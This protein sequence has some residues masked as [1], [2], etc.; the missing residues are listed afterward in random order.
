MKAREERDKLEFMIDGAESHLQGNT[1]APG[2]VPELESEPSF[3]IDYEK[4]QKTCDKQAKKLLKNAT[5]L[6]IG[7]ELTKDNSYIRY[8]IQTDVISLGGMLYQMEITKIMQQDLVEEVRLGAKHPRMYE[9]FSTLGKTISDN[10]KQLLQTVEAIKETYVTLRQNIV[11]RNDDIK[12]LSMGVQDTPDG[13][14][15]TVGSR[16]LIDDAKRLRLLNR[17]IKEEKEIQDIEEVII[18]D[19]DNK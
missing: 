2:D 15:L 17:K 3:S 6:M 7:D 18:V 4:L 11:E 16:D 14:L 8:K 9:V 12:Q 13:G 19:P 1:P 5:G 10:N